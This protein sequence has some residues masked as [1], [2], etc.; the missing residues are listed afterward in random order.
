MRGNL[1]LY[2]GAV[3]AI[4]QSAFEADTIQKTQLISSNVS[5]GR[6]TIDHLKNVILGEKKFTLLNYPKIE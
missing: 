2:H 3:I 4:F 6:H 1:C 5:I